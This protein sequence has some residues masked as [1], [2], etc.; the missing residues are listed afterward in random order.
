M[1]AST[2]NQYSM[3]GREKREVGAAITK[4]AL[5]IERLPLMTLNKFWTSFCSIHGSPAV[6]TFSAI[7]QCKL[8]M[9]FPGTEAAYAAWH[10]SGGGGGG[11]HALLTEDYPARLCGP[12]YYHRS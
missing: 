3:T 1:F 9:I 2:H 7:G 4:P 6:F 12:G 8:F 11:F 10:E 5:V